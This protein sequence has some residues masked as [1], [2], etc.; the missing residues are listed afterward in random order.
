MTTTIAQHV[1]VSYDFPVIF[2][3]DALDI[4]NPVL[5]ST[6]GRAGPGPHRMVFVADSGV[7]QAFPNILMRL[8]DYC[9][10]N[11]SAITLA[12]A[13]LMVPGGEQA[14]ADMQVVNMVLETI[15]RQG[16]CRQ[17]FVVA[18]GG[19]A[20]LDAVGFAAAM[21]HRGV[22]LIRMPSTVL[23]QNDAGVGVKNGINW[24]GRKNFL[25]TFAPPFAVI[26]DY[27]LLAGLA[28][29]D[30]RAGLSEA[31][32][33]AL[34]RDADFFQ[35][36]WTNRHVLGALEQAPLECS[37]ERCATLHMRHIAQGNDPFEFGSS[38]PLDFGHWCAH[39]MEERSGGALGHGAAVAVG[40]A[41]D[42]IYSHLTGLIGVADLGRILTVLEDMGFA[43]WHP[44]LDGLDVSTAVEAFREH[45]GG[46]LSLS[47]IQGLGSRI[48]VDS[49]D[50]PRMAQAMENLKK[51][52]GA[53]TAKAPPDAQ[54]RRDLQ[55]AQ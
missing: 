35:W 54:A 36:L 51:R 14:K 34:I 4:S 52:H 20:V 40:V 21:A 19:G 3:R 31:V 45:L 5:A 41:L 50:L 18:L 30:R 39:A 1:R 42:S 23:A 25:G 26:N 16:I 48:E 22:R 7:V 9:E 11:F 32:K 10:A 53:R 12:Q 29:E 8:S 13:P 55:A 46:E 38:R 33:I 17:S 49:V 28:P 15:F 37:V 47:L 44:S 6:L 24:F 2:T 27:A 43:L